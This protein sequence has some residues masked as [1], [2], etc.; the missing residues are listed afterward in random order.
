MLPRLAGRLDGGFFRSLGGVDGLIPLSFDPGDL[1]S[2]SSRGVE[3][4]V[5]FVLSL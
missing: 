3:G 1:L 2:T 5:V 4:V